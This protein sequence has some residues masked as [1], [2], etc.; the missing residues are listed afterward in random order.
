MAIY[1]MPGAGEYLDTLRAKPDC[2]LVMDEP[3]PDIHY[4]CDVHPDNP[5]QG[6]WVLAPEPSPA[7]PRFTGNAKLDLFTQAEQLAVVQA[8]MTDAH[9]K[10]MY[11]RLIGAAFWTYEDPETE[12]GLSLL[13]DKDLLT[14]ERKAEIVTAMQPG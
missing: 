13:V 11:D 7:F 9:V 5:A 3:R 14:A 10:L 2:Y 8:T 6:V 1:A 12:R 4:I